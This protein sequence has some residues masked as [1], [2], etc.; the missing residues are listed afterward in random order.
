MKKS[1]L[2]VLL[3]LIS[4]LSNAMAK[5][6]H[7]SEIKDRIDHLENS[8]IAEFQFS[9]PEGYAQK[10]ES[11]LQLSLS[12]KL[13]NAWR[14]QVRI[15]D[16][17][18]SNLF[19]IGKS[20]QQK[21][22]TGLLTPQESKKLMTNI[23]YARRIILKSRKSEVIEQYTDFK[24]KLQVKPTIQHLFSKITKVSLPG[25]CKIQDAH[26]EGNFLTFEVLGLGKDGE[27][28]SQRYT[29]TKTDVELGSLTTRSNG[30]VSI[31]DNHKSILSFKAT[32]SDLSFKR[33]DLFENSDGEFYHAE[34]AHEDMIKPLINVWGFDFGEKKVS[35]EIFC[36]LQGTSPASLEEIQRKKILKNFEDK[37]TNLN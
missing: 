28:L 33:F 17:A 37:V 36:N 16:N 31:S 3:V 21:V 30:E 2:T 12:K 35:Q 7:Y 19:A 6:G 32:E 34:F 14:E 29:V 9:I 5:T 11:T 8:V 22:K 27:S 15:F 18:E 20:L 13:E 25:S 24:N 1:K 10:F 26:L 4:L 23:E